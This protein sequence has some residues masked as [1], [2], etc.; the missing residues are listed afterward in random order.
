MNQER[1]RDNS[2]RVARRRVVSRTSRRG[3]T[4]VELLMVIVVIGVLSSLL[5]VA[6][7]SVLGTS[8]EA[9]TKA[10]LSKIN[11]MLK[12]R[13]SAFENYLANQ[14]RSENHLSS[15]FINELPVGLGALLDVPNNERLRKIVYRKWEF[16]KY[17][18]QNWQ[19]AK[20]LIHSSDPSVT[21]PDSETSST[22]PAAKAE[23]AEV[24]YY[25]LTETGIV[26]QGEIGKDAFLARE[27]ADTDGDGRK[28]IVDGWGNPLWIYRWP[29]RLI[30]PTPM[31]APWSDPSD[32]ELAAART[33]ISALTTN[34]GDKAI[35]SDPDDPFDQISVDSSFVTEFLKN[36]HIPKAYHSILVVSAGVDG[37][38]GLESPVDFDLMDNSVDTIQ[39]RVVNV[40][41]LY[42][43][44]TNLNALAGGSQ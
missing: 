8:R 27:L 31:S 40:A 24:L 12:E 43:N 33:Q 14:Y 25:V 37:A 29:C 21:V 2:I 36:F 17:F 18:P 44:L 6:S 4:L 28:E 34:T 19:E 13:M 1:F 9:A 22:T 15:S 16:Q 42:D 10:T 32:P 35:N 11:T 3:F 39:G 38:F 20:R 5:I 23:S 7:M 30:K 41:E 26:N